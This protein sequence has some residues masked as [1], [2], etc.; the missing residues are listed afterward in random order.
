MGLPNWLHW[1]AWFLKS[2]SF[3]FISIILMVV[4]LKVSWYTNTDYTV[5][6]HANAFVLLIFLFFYGCAIITFCFAISVFFSKGL[7]KWV[8]CRL[9]VILVI[10]ANTAATMAGFAYFVCY[11][12]YSFMQT[13]YESLSLATKLIASLA[14]NTGMAFGF[15]IILMYEG[16]GEGTILLP[17]SL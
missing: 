9:K 10:P 5:F 7:L 13:N 2:F 12:P 14:A 6:T 4:L 15:Q 8:L 1:T 17:Y 3:L 11:A 16:T